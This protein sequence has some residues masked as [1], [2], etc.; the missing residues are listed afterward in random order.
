MIIKKI[1]PYV[2]IILTFLF[3]I[4]IGTCFLALPI[5]SSSGKSFGF[6]NSL[7]MS[8]SAVCVTGLSVVNVAN[9]MSIFGHIVMFFLMEIGGLSFLTIA[10][11]F[12]TILGAKLGVSNT[13]LLK[14][15]LNQ[16]SLNGIISL[17]KKIMII[18]FTI[19]IVGSLIN[20]IVLIPYYDNNVLKAI[21]VSLFHS[22]ASFNNA[23]FDIFGSD[24]LI[25]FSDNLIINS[26][27]MLMILFGGLGF[28]VIDDI[29]KA[30]S[31]KKLSLHSKIT[32]ITTL[33]LTIIGTLLLKLSMN[34]LSFLEALFLSITTRTA[35]FTTIDLT[36]LTPGAY[37]TSI[38]LMFVG[39]SPCSTGGGIKTTT[40]AIVF[41]A[42]FSFARGKKLNIFKR[43]IGDSIIFKAFVLF[44]IGVLIDIIGIIL[45]SLIQPELGIKEIVFEVVSAFSTTGLSMGI[46]SS[47][48]WTN[49]LIIVILMFFGRIGPLTIIG[50][51]N[52]NWMNDKKENIRYVEGSVIVG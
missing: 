41:L 40:L 18:S 44:T 38:C 51:V 23:G 47:L 35:G 14:E 45:V 3:V 12:F 27:T 32:I 31:V 4:L 48:N 26:T 15:S 19:Q 49:K 6:V 22:A 8:T 39:A 11:F 2:L 30:K 7:F 16:N 13:F 9:E 20:L 10:V 21:G 52:R 25:Y 42:I 37:V 29:L 24:S 50:V 5:S 43:R 1:H 36:S 28:V 34:S 46:T 33:L 17:V